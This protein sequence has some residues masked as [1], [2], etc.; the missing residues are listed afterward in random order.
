MRGTRW[1]SG[2][3]AFLAA[4]GAAVAGT[5]TPDWAN[6]FSA[7]GLS[8]GTGTLEAR[9]F[10]TFNG[11]LHVAGRFTMGG[12]VTVNHIARWT[13]A[14]WASLLGG[15][16]STINTLY[17]W[18]EDGAGPNPPRLFLGGIFSSLNS[19]TISRI[20]RWDGASY[21]SLGAGLTGAVN[22]LIS[23]DD[24]SGE[25]LFAA[26]LFSASGTGGG[27]IAMSRIGKW[28]GTTWSALGNAVAGGGA[29]DA[30]NA[31]AIH[32]DGTGEALFLG[33]QFITANGVSV[34]RTAKWN[35]TN[36][37][38]LN[39]GSVLAGDVFAMVPFD[40]DGA[41]PNPPRLFVGGAFTT[42][43]GGTPMR[44]IARWDGANWT[45]VGDG[46]N[47]G[48]VLALSVFDDGSGSG[49]ALFAGGSF[50]NVADVGMTVVNGVAKWTGTTWAAIDGGLTGGAAPRAQ[51]LFVHDDGMGPDLYVGGD[52]TMSG[53]VATTRIAK[54][55]RAGGPFFSDQPDDL[56]LDSGQTAMFSVTAGGTNPLTYQ[57]RRDGVNLMNGGNVAGA[58]S[59]MLTVSNVSEA[60]NGDYTVRVNNTCGPAISEAGTL[61]VMGASCTGD[62][63][64]DGQVNSSD[65]AV[66]LA[67]WGPG[68]GPADL[69][70]DGQVN[71]SDLAVVLASWGICP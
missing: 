14:S 3:L 8:G 44:R 65:L 58:T 19:V 9:A 62:I 21:S 24:G 68:G 18:D 10:S 52:F 64:G 6:T 63:T 51:A 2:S 15:A 32:D 35:G 36:F 54:R 30:V 33:G 67:S 20:G 38:A 37:S 41:G 43:T 16:S 69:T 56:E 71:S 60:D 49:P 22:A 66:V 5:C 61:T 42:I 46:F 23:W 47:N 31:L 29:S 55:D 11:D 57:W 48:Q 40:E 4:A 70:M 27:A 1:V 13:G 7:A 53:A 59:A 26:G 25:A 34:F 12:G 17:T 39:A 28:N 45:A 50:V